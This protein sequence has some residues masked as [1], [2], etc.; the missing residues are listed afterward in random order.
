MEKKRI[1]RLFF[2]WQDEKE[3]AWLEQMAAHGW[4]LDEVGFI[5]Y[6][7]RKEQ[8]QA[9]RY[10][11]DYQDVKQDELQEY[12]LLFADAGWEYIGRL[13][14][15]FYFA[16]QESTAVEIYTDAHSKVAKY[17]RVMRT[18]LVASF[19][20]V[21]YLV[22]YFRSFAARGSSV[23]FL[24]M[25]LIQFLLFIVWLILMINIVRIW[26]KVQEIEKGM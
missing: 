12:L 14:N 11:L 13:N 23:P 16:A 8:P 19:P 6:T 7:F 24:M 26:A 2:A 18:L 15:W 20:L 1:F 9:I 4:I 5:Q 21:Y 25:Y 22:F 10:R 17:K 3:Q